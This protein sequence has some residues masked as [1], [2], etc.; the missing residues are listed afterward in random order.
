MTDIVDKAVQKYNF[1]CYT[2]W[3]SHCV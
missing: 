3:V 2:R 1:R